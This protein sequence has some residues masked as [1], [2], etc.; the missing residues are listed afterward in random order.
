MLFEE[1][2]KAVYLLGLNHTIA[3]AYEVNNHGAHHRACWEAI[4]TPFD[5]PH[6]MLYGP[7]NLEVEG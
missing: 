6:M 5:T 3:P 7:S 4:T 1:Q 2:T